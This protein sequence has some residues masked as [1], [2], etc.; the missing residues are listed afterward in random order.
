[1]TYPQIKNYLEQIDRL[2]R[3]RFYTKQWR[4]SQAR[5]NGL[6]ITEAEYPIPQ[7]WTRIFHRRHP[8]Q[9]MFFHA[10]YEVGDR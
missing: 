8:I 3:G 10:L 4:V 1:M 5:V 7:S 6:V 2:C 9:R